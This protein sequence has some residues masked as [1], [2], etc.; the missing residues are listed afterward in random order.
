MKLLF[1]IF[2]GTVYFIGFIYLLLP[3]PVTPNLS[4]S[5]LS[6][7]PGDTWQHPEQKAFFTQDNRKNILDEF[8]NNFSLSIFNFQLPSFRLN[9]RPEET[10]EF[11]REQVA[12]N[13][14]EEI[15]HPLRESLYVT[16]WEPRNAPLWQDLPFEDRPR[17]KKYNQLF[18]TKVTLRPVYSSAW[19]RVFIW[20]LIFP[21]AYLVWQSFKKSLY[22]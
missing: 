14:L 2:F 22:A 12:S 4:N 7:E 1:K 5:F 21:S 11:V 20:S 16:G 6:D 13:Y 19:Q 9:Y 18:N 8:E 15:V 3:N 17:I 10:T